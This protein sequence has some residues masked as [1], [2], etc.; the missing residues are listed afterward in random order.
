MS[1]D[2]V[3][4]P[5]VMGPLTLDENIKAMQ[6]QIQSDFQELLQ[7]KDN[8]KKQSEMCSPERVIADVDKINC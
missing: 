2:H 3:I 5:P 7:C 1:A 4:S 8:V 6:M